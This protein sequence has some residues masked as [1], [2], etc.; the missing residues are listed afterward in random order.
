MWWGS[1]VWSV[2]IPGSRYVIMPRPNR[3]QVKVR[4]VLRSTE[5]EG[6]VATEFDIGGDR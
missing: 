4:N 5:E 3:P 2:L 6:E 1:A